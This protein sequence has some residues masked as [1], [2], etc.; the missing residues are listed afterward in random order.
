MTYSKIGSA[1]G[2]RQETEWLWI[3]SWNV[4]FSN[5][6]TC[7]S[8]AH[9]M[10]YIFIMYLLLADDSYNDWNI[11]FSLRYCGVLVTF[12]DKSLFFLFFSFFFFLF[13]FLIILY[14][15]ETGCP[16][17]FCIFLLP[18][19]VLYISW[20]HYYYHYY[21]YKYLLLFP[22]HFS[23]NSICSVTYFFT[24]KRHH[25]LFPWNAA[26]TRL[27]GQWNSR[28]LIS[29]FTDML[30]VAIS[31][32][33]VR[34]TVPG[35]MISPLISPDKALFFHNKIVF[36]F[37]PAHDKTSKMACAPSEDSDQPGHPPSLIR[38]FAVR[39]TGS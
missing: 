7:I 15:T 30:K 25:L 37:Q 1:P 5:G 19:K 16:W 27:T 10:T 14:S 31:I 4:I 38:V 39:S 26:I 11:F 24:L 23:E 21:F 32:W 12:N 8:L 9:T 36:I 20:K 35:Q 6:D 33:L 3:W 17:I 22:S 28:Q 2:R 18:R 34:N 13:L 29:V